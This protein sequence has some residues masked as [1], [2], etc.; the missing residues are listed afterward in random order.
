MRGLQWAV[1]VV[2]EAVR[3][4]NWLIAVECKKNN[5]L[6]LVNFL[7]LQP[8]LLLLLIVDY[9]LAQVAYLPD[10]SFR[11]SLISIDAVWP[12]WWALQNIWRNKKIAR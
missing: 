8:P 12:C 5:W 6:W 11:L 7:F 9:A 10:C 4:R 2:D 3:V 1:A